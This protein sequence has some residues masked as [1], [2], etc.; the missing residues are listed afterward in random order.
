M[1]KK[2]LLKHVGCVE[3]IGGIKDYTFNDDYDKTF[4]G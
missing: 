2:E 3:Q 4:C 1:N